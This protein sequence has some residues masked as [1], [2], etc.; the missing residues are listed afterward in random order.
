MIGPEQAEPV[1]EAGEKP[2]DRP[3]SACVGGRI[4]CQDGGVP[5]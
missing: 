3:R 2:P 1:S 4:L 5:E